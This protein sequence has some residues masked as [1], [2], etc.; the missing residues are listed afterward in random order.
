MSENIPISVFVISRNE[1]NNIE[2][3][4]KSVKWCDEIVLVDAF[5]TDNTVNKA[6]NFTDRIFL[7]EW[8]GF[9]EQKTYALEKT[10]SEWVL[11]LD[12][13]ER[14]TPELKDEIL[15]VLEDVNS[16]NGF[17]I[18]RKS[19]FLDRWIKHSG[20]YPGYQMRLF[21][22]EKTRVSQ[23]RVHEGFIVEGESAHLMQPIVHYTHPTISDSLGKMNLY[24]PLEAE[25]RVHTKNI[26]W[27]D[28]IA[29]PLSAFL[30]KYIA[31]KGFLDGMPGL[32]LAVITAGLKMALYMKL[33]EKQQ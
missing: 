22:K 18:P 5:S 8:D 2:D 13:D 6:R 33:W 23:K 25:D 29:H 10:C 1:E 24:S 30:R 14:V 11:S 19:Y 15:N 12:A 27:F 21:R 20:W 9:S 4:L 32:I 3:C 7:R 16:V 28:L 26:R 31:Q 17:F